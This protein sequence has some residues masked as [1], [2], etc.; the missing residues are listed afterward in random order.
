MRKLL[1]ILL[2]LVVCMSSFMACSKKTNNET[3]AAESEITENDIIYQRYRL[4][5]AN[6][7]IAIA[8]ETSTFN[9][10]PFSGTTADGYPYTG[11]VQTIADTYNSLS[12]EVTE[13]ENKIVV[14]EYF[15]VDANLMFVAIT[16]V[17]IT[18]D[19]TTTFDVSKYLVINS[20]DVIKVNHIM[21]ED[22]LTATFD[23]VET[24]PFTSLTYQDAVNT[25]VH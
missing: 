22:P 10:I 21:G 14:T 11:S 20:T 19:G 5:D 23:V 13:S 15:D 2:I 18:E 16:I 8:D 17:N 7:S 3:A 9:S 4:W 25:Y 1:S 12:V 24:A 6:R